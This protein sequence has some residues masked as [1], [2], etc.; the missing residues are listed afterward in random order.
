ME[1]FG[2][3]LNRTFVIFVTP[4]A[5]YGW[6]GRG[7]VTNMRSMYFPP[8]AQLLDNLA[9]MHNREAIQKL[10]SLKGGFVIPRSQVLGV[11]LVGRKKWGMGAFRILDEFKSK[12][13][14]GW[15]ARVCLDFENAKPLAPYRRQRDPTDI[16]SI[17]EAKAGLIVANVYFG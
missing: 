10:A 1:Y 16:L 3:I 4:E 9:L 13:G 11:E 7:P 12:H 6:K 14:F 8:Y 17:L 5:L 2:L 15:H